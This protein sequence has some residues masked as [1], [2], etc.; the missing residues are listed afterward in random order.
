MVRSKEVVMSPQRYRGTSQGKNAAK[1]MAAETGQMVAARLHTA[2]EQGDEAPRFWVPDGDPRE[3]WRL[4]KVVECVEG[5]MVLEDGEEARV[6]VA[7]PH[8]ATHDLDLDDVCGMADLHEAPLLGLLRR[9]W[10][11]GKIYTAAGNVLISI[12]PYREVVVPVNFLEQWAMDART[13]LKATGQNQAMVVNGES[14]AGKTMASTLIIEYLGSKNEMLLATTPVLEAFGNAKTAMN[15]NSSRFGKFVLLEYDGKGEIEGAHVEDFLLEKSRVTTC[16]CGDRNFHFFYQI[17]CSSSSSERRAYLPELAEGRRSGEAT[18]R[19]LKTL[20]CDVEWLKR[21]GRAC[22]VLGDLEFCEDEDEELVIEGPLE[23]VAALLRVEAADLKSSLH[24]RSIVAEGET[25]HI[26]YTAV[27]GVAAR[28]ALAKALY[29]KVFEFVVKKCNAAIRRPSVLMSSSMKQRASEIEADSDDEGF[30]VEATSKFIGILDIYGFEIMDTNSLDQLLIN[31]ANETLQVA[32]N[33]EVLVAETTRYRDEGIAWRGVELSDSRACLDLIHGILTQLDEQV[34]LGLRG[35]DLHFLG[36]CDREFADS[37][38]FYA[39]PRFGINESFVVKHYAGDVAYTAHGFLKRNVDPLS[40]DLADLVRSSK[41]EILASWYPAGYGES[42]R[43]R[44]RRLLG[45]S[46]SKKF[47]DQM[48]MLNEELKGCQKHYIRCIRPNVSKSP[49]EFHMDLVLRQLRFFGILDI[50]RIRRLGFPEQIDFEAFWRA[51]SRLVPISESDHRW[52]AFEHLLPAAEDEGSSMMMFA[53]RAAKMLEAGLFFSTTA[54]KKYKEEIDALEAERTRAARYNDQQKVQELAARIDHLK[55]DDILKLPPDLL[56]AVEAACSLLLREDEFA[57]GKR[58]GKLYAKL[59]VTQRLDEMLALAMGVELSMA[60]ERQSQLVA[61]SRERVNAEAAATLFVQTRLRA[62][63]AQKAYKKD[64]QAALIIERATR[65][66]L[67]RKEARRRRT[68]RA[69]EYAARLAR[70]KADLAA[71]ETYHAETRALARAAGLDDDD[72]DEHVVAVVVVP[73]TTTTTSDIILLEEDEENG[74]DLET[75]KRIEALEAARDEA[76]SKADAARDYVLSTCRARQ[77]ELA[78]ALSARVQE[79]SARA[80]KHGIGSEETPLGVVEALLLKTKEVAT[81][82]DTEA[83]E[84]AVSEYE[85][86]VAEACREILSKTLR[87]LERRHA[88]VVQE[89]EKS[90]SV[91]SAI[92]AAEKALARASL[93]EDDAVAEADAKVRAEEDLFES[94]ARACA[95]ADLDACADR[96]KSIARKAARAPGGGVHLLPEVEEAL[97]ALDAA[98]CEDAAK[99][100]TLLVRRRAREA[101]AR[102]EALQSL[103]DGACLAA[104]AATR[105]EA[106]VRAAKQ[107]KIYLAR[108]AAATKVQALA[109][110]RPLARSFKKQKAEAIVVETALRGFLARRRFAKTIAA[111]DNAAAL[112]IETWWRAAVASTALNFVRKLSRPWEAVLPSRREFVVVATVVVWHRYTKAGRVGEMV[113]SRKLNLLVTNRGNVVLASGGVSVYNPETDPS[114]V[115]VLE[116]AKANAK[117]TIHLPNQTNFL[118]GGKNVP[119]GRERPIAV[120]D[121]NEFPVRLPV[122]RLDLKVKKGIRTATMSISDLAGTHDRWRILKDIFDARD[123]ASLTPKRATRLNLD[124]SIANLPIDKVGFLFKSPF[125]RRVLR[126]EALQELLENSADRSSSSGRPKHRTS[127]TTKISTTV[128]TVGIKHEE[129]ERLFVLQGGILRYYKR[130]ADEVPKGQ[131]CLPVVGG[132]S[133][134]G[135]IQ[136]EAEAFQFT[137]K[138]AEFPEGITVKAHDQ[139]DMMAWRLAIESAIATDL[140]QKAKMIRRKKDLFL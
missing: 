68:A 101:L 41:D 48:A 111:R 137:V 83:A 14:G 4:V 10:K 97:A 110:G 140:N 61:L 74:V 71:I 138:T 51:Y 38:P 139:D 29:E 82:R 37:N 16:G 118:D 100:T 11:A 2:R 108:V 72:D 63:T 44:E 18:F 7:H 12:N 88:A 23:E 117:L 121:P 34:K 47:R 13:Q 21:V 66:Y 50:V 84:A 3:L 26:P 122:C 62:N 8:D 53:T 130:E 123:F 78:A 99:A 45:E 116:G 69:K 32:F 24:H 5:K 131:L 125:K 15:D 46:T 107:R 25:R 77:Q 87:S 73:T 60:R 42:G 57:I 55:N 76:R 91:A 104:K 6:T 90:G 22:V 114:V 133:S 79:A 28:D 75:T 102:T 105:M 17:F 81:K 124:H 65:S 31:L 85:K 56:K 35:S 9:R 52:H 33:Q 115:R 30:G 128:E 92:E 103:V 58:S 96:R 36:C 70:A 127:A 106:K 135:C 67:A 112:R 59:G 93:L 86:T 43:Q 20:G 120:V 1:V 129:K 113:G 19:A 27:Q 80:E 54:S 64:K 126:A 49:D 119:A 136:L 40:N 89:A 132:I 94:T 134:E 39:K 95:L 109:R 98:L